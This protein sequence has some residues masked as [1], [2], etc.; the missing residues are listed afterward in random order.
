MNDVL[1]LSSAAD[2]EFNGTEAQVTGSLLPTEITDG[3]FINNNLGVTLSDS[4]M[5]SGG[6]T[7]LILRSGTL[8]TDTDNLL[9]FANNGSWDEA[10]DSSF[11]SGPVAKLSDSVEGFLFPVGKG[12]LYAPMLI[13]SET[14]DET[15]FKAEYFENSYQGFYNTDASL[16]SVSSVEH[17]ILERLSGTANAKVRL[18]WGEHSFETLPDS[19]VVAHLNGTTWI[20]EGQSEIDLINKWITSEVISEFSP[21]TLGSALMEA[22]PLSTPENIQIQLS[23][24]QFTISWDSVSEASSYTIYSSNDPY[25]ETWNLLESGII[26]S[27]YTSDANE[28]FKFLRVTANE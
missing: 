5:I 10:G 9:V 17:W 14:T 7:G 16:E 22:Q 15:I 13:A 23:E 27:Q 2:Y 12:T 8:F 28:N 11:I 24:S 26:E 20:N 4:T 6:N 18:Y 1:T 21:F 3:L 25:A 19:L